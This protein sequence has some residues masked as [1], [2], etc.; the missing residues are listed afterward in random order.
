MGGEGREK[1]GHVFSADTGT[2]VGEIMGTS[3]AI[4]SVD[5]KPT[6]PFRAV[7]ASEDNSICYFEGPP[8]KWKKTI[9]EHERFVNVI[10]YSPSGDHFVSG[11]A[12]GKLN[13]F[14]GKTG[15]KLYEIVNQSTGGPAHA[16]SIYSLCWDPTSKMVLTVSG[17]KSAKLWNINEK[18]LVKEFKFGD[19]VDDQQV[20]CLWQNEHLL[21]VSLSGNINYLNASNDD[22]LVLKTIKGHSKSVTALEVAYANTASPLIVSGSHDGL[23]VHWNSTNGQMDVVKSGLGSGQHKN[24]VQAIRFDSL[25]DTLITCGLDDMLKFIDAKELKYVKDIKLDS[26]PQG[27]DVNLNNHVVV[28]CISKLVLLKNKDVLC[29]INLNYDATSVTLT[30]NANF[31]AVGGKDNKV[32]IYEINS[33]LNT[34]VEVTTLQE[35]DFI[36]AVRYSNNDEY[37]AVADNAKN[38]KCYKLDSANKSSY[39]E[40]TRDLWQHHAGKITSLAWSPDSTHLATSSVDTHCFIYSPAKSSD[41]VHIKNAHPLNPLTGCAWLNNNHLV[42][43][44]QDCCI[45][46]WKLNF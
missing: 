43:S 12:D 25:S 13:V 19:S 17:D 3:K 1:F 18:S 28:A 35:R 36:T 16:G 45:R 30:R 5:F 34:F 44:S 10:R 20:A 21:S 38:V 4:N 29:S 24:Q 39:S 33:T 31:V 14:D 41:F 15:D 42:T 22:R 11:G 2:S 7:V 8:F 6:R 46:K 26:Q 27:L 37:L 40:I 23:I 32:H 9:N